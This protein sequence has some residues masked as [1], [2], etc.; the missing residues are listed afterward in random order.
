[1]ETS[2]ELD[3]PMSEIPIRWRTS[4]SSVLQV[5]SAVKAVKGSVFID[6]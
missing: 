3:S 6:Q 1:M 4:A 5:P 2:E